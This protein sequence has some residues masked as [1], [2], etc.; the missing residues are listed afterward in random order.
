[1]N[2]TKHPIEQLVFRIENPEDIADFIECD[3][4]IWTQFLATQDGYRSKEVWVND[5]TLG[6]VHTILIWET[7]AH[8][9]Q[10]PELELRAKD[11]EFKKAFGRSFKMVRRIHQETNHGMHQ[12][13]RHEKEVE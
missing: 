3:H 1:M 8:W 2:L 9:K 6:E 4:A 7:L 12:V 13:C 5:D 10:I 11:E